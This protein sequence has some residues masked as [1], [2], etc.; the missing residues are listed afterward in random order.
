MGQIS[1]H[2]ACLRLLSKPDHNLVQPPVLP[3]LQ[4]H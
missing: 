3:L 1:E 4:F 2:F